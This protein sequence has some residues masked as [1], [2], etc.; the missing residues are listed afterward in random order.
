MLF[1]S[2]KDAAIAFADKA[3]KLQGLHERM[4]TKTGKDLKRRRAVQE[5]IEKFKSKFYRLA[6]G[7]KTTRETVI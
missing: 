1:K 5:R 6:R 3:F 2:V 4:S 7:S